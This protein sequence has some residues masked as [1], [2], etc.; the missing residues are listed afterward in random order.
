M[1][2]SCCSTG[3]Q[4]VD[5]THNA[6]LKRETL[7]GARRWG[8]AGSCRREVFRWVTRYNTRRRHSALGYRSPLAFESVH[9]AATV[10]AEA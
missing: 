8:S 7:Q 10:S 2:G 3:L 5:H 9:T 1:A 6:S 4:R